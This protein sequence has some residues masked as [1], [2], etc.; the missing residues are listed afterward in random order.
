MIELRPKWEI[1]A[2][3]LAMGDVI[4]KAYVKAGY[5]SKWPGSDGARLLRTHPEIKARAKEIQERTFQRHSDLQLVGRVDL[6][7]GVLENIQAAKKG[8]PVFAK[9]GSLLGHSRDF[10]AI[11]QAY[12]LLA[13]VEGLIVRRSEKKVIEG[14]VVAEA[15]PAELIQIV[16]NAF[17]KLGI[18]FD[19]TAFKH[20]LA[21]PTEP[22]QA[23]DGSD[24]KFPQVLPALP[25]AAGVS[26]EGGEVP[27]PD[28]DGG[29][30]TWEVGGGFGGGGKPPD[31]P[32]PG[33]LEGEEVH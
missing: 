17:Q 12:K 29:E 11:N 15:G 6:I 28:A 24:A 10:G 19:V 5:K 31:R 7:E 20:L 3:R 4:S 30:P 8:K 9:N 1:I 13:D 22:G 32:V 25:E 18:E 33:G 27:V 2:Q 23:G 14:D 26:R 21:G 16:D